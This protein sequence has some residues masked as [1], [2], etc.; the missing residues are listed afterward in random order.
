MPLDAAN[1]GSL[2]V[3]G[4]GEQINRAVLVVGGLTPV[5]TQP[6]SYHYQIEPAP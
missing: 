2:T 4:L 5:T 6:A 3:T 1:R